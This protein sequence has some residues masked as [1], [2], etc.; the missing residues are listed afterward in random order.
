[1]FLLL[2]WNMHICD[3]E[4]FW[5]ETKIKWTWFFYISRSPA[6]I[7]NCHPFWCFL[8]NIKIYLIINDSDRAKVKA[9][10]YISFIPHYLPPSS[11]EINS[12]SIMPAWFSQLYISLYEISC[13]YMLIY[14]HTHIHT[15]FCANWSYLI[16]LQLVFWFL[17]HKVSWRSFCSRKM[18]K[19]PLYSFWCLFTTLKHSVI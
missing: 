3:E 8:S 14:I 12:N 13:N 4:F 16:F 6:S 9:H 10:G 11:E 17:S 19:A 1:M 7:K 18:Y 5:K 15:I 2:V